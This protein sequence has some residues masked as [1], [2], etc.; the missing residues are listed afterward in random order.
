MPLDVEVIV[1]ADLKL[2]LEPEKGVAR[3]SGADALLLSNR[4]AIIVDYDRFMKESFQNRLR[5]T[6]AHE[7]G[8]FVLHEDVYRAV[9]FSS[10]EEWA[11][12]F[13]TIPRDKYGWL[14]WQADEF[15]GRLLIESGLLKQKFEEAKKKLAGTAYEKL[16]PLPEPV[17]E[18]MSEEIG[19]F[20]GV[21][22][23]PVIIRLQRE[24][25]WQPN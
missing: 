23:Q 9:S 13:D 20:F 8:H 17:V 2:R 22:Y 3:A 15:A 24:N 19:R 7:I 5:F 18:F 16:D 4:E 12:F 1:E 25:I 6:I 10:V 14:E 21:S 11:E